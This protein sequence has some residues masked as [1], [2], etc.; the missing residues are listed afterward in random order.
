EV[1]G[2]HEAQFACELMKAIEP[3]SGYSGSDVQSPA[4]IKLKYETADI[5][6]QKN[7]Y[8]L[9]VPGTGDAVLIQLKLDE[10][11]PRLSSKNDYNFLYVTNHAIPTGKNFNREGLLQDLRAFAGLYCWKSTNAL[12]N[13]PGKEPKKQQEVYTYKPQQ[14]S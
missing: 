10:K 12:S 6:G 14:K 7:A 4:P 13:Q 3:S 9:N 5:L 8:W 11:E 1:I 2:M